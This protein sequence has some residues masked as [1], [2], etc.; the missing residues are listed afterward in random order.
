MLALLGS[1]FRFVYEN[2]LWLAMN[3]AVP[4]L[5]P[6][7]VVGLI[8]IS[9]A[10]TGKDRTGRL[11]ARLLLRESVDRGQLFWTAIA[12]QAATTYDAVTAWDT[13]LNDHSTIGSFIGGCAFVSFVCTVLVGLSTANSARHGTTNRYVICISITVIALMCFAYPLVHFRFN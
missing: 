12:L 11:T 8:A 7:V 5:L 9:E 13:H 4:I 3:L 6:Y 1:F 2:G 10:T